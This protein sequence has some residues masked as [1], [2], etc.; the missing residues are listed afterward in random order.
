MRRIKCGVIGLGFFGEKHVEV[1]SSLPHVEVAAV[2]TRREQRLQEMSQKYGVP[3]VYTDYNDL[4]ADNEI[5]A[6]SIVTHARDHL[7]PTLAAIKA[8]KHIFLEKPMALATAECDRIIE[9]LK[10]TEKSFMVGHICRFDPAYAV[11]RRSIGEGRIGKILSIY[12][13]RNI[14]AAVSAGVLA[15]ISPITGDGVHDIDIML[16]YTGSRVKAV[17]AA[18]V[19]VRGLANPDI[20]WAMYRFEN[21]AIGV[22]ENN[23]CL[24]KGTPFELDARMEIIGEKGAIYINSPGQA[25]SINTEEGWTYPETVYWPR[26]QVGRAG[27]L[28]EELSYFLDCILRGEKPAIITPEE[29]RAAVAAVEAAEKAARS[30]EVVN[31]RES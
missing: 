2:C 17:S 8:G 5:E 14:P 12:A 19:D 7:L 30:G 9:A 20:G 23:W 10:T 27:A 16:W 22:T 25:L 15:D 28:K 21:G 3:T 31:V 1:L 11:A 18:T 26:T 24:P 6:V 29:S 4:L 13:R